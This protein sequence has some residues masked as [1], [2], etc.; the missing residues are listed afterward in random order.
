MKKK[1]HHQRTKHST[2]GDG[3]K[4]EDKKIKIVDLYTAVKAAYE[5]LQD[6]RYKLFLEAKEHF[7]KKE[8]QDA[9]E[10]F[11]EILDNLVQESYDHIPRGKSI[12]TAEALTNH[13]H[14]DLLRRLRL[15]KKRQHIN[16]VANEINL[17]DQCL[18]PTKIRSE[19]Q[20]RTLLD[21]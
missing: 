16:F 5:A 20:V 7:L 1:S 14:H 3:H 8:Y 12:K 17:L 2:K 9:H 15:E 21:S 4:T 13:L 11:K 6:G 18:Y 10:K 19:S